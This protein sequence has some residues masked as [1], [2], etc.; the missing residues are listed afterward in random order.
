LLL[1]RTGTPTIGWERAV[2]ILNFG[3]LLAFMAV[4]ASALRHFG[5]GGTQN[6]ERN[7]LMDFRALA[8]GFVLCLGMFR[9]LHASTLWA[10][11]LWLVIGDV[12]VLLMRRG[13]TERVEIDFSES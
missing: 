10:G 2:E 7:L 3:A 5:F 8:S 9:G 1:A 11:A 13:F 12:Y 4:N 6:M